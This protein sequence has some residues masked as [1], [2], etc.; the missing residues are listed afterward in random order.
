M[1]GKP[2][3]EVSVSDLPRLDT[4]NEANVSGVVYLRRSTLT[5]PDLIKLPY[6]TASQLLCEEL[7]SA[8]E[9][10]LKHQNELER[11]AGIPTFELH[12]DN[13]EEAI[14]QLDGL[15]ESL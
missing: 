2:S 13:L 14:S 8:G 1:E 10:R 11:L 3:I 15:A 7:Y 4:S 12:Y 6:G 9:I 5:R